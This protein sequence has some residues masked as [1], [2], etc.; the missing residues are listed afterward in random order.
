MRW[1]LSA[2]IVIG[3]G[4]VALAGCRSEWSGPH[5]VEPLITGPSDIHHSNRRGSQAARG[6][7]SA[8]ARW[9]RGIGA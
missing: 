9:R 6:G 4:Q 2:R 3:G 8:G 5:G 7:P 1:E